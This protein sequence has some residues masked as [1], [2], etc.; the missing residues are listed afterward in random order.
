MKEKSE[1]ALVSLQKTARE[2]GIPV[3]WLRDQAE[4]GT[5]PGLRAG[6]R[7]LFIPEIATAAVRALAGDALLIDK[8]LQSLQSAAQS[9]DPELI[10]VAREKLQSNH[11]DALALVDPDSIQAKKGVP[12]DSQ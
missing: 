4:A 8:S 3:K 10:K 5:I 2:L 1:G 9:G 12:H 6:N 7:W 11:G